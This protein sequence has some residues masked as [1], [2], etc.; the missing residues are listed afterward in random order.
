MALQVVA[1]EVQEAVLPKVGSQSATRK[2]DGPVS[3]PGTYD[4]PSDVVHVKQEESRWAVGFVNFLLVSRFKA[5]NAG[6]GVAINNVGCCPIVI[7]SRLGRGT[8]HLAAL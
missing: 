4:G 1:R 3:T 8:S 7:C 6:K 5:R 2:Y